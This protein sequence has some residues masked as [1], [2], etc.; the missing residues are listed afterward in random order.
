M[1]PPAA[2]VRAADRKLGK[3]SIDSHVKDVWLIHSA[4]SGGHGLRVRS[5][6]LSAGGLPPA[7][8]VGHGMVMSGKTLLLSLMMKVS[9]IPVDPAVAGS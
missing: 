6:S 5:F 4:A 3:S 1:V 8:G 9:A 7:C 2:A